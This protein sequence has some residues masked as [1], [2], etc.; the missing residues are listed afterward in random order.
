[1]PRQEGT[2]RA[3]VWRGIHDA[4]AIARTLQEHEAILKAIENHDGPLA[5][6]AMLV[7]VA[8][9]HQWLS[10]QPDQTSAPA[11]LTEFE[12]LATRV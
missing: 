2:W 7:H 1:M 12:A 8:A 3:R 4:G 11:A 5:R 10:H 9:V 6:A